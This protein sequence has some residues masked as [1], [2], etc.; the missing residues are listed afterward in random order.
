VQD[1][2]L[3]TSAARE[4]LRDPDKVLAYLRQSVV[5]LARDTLRR[6]LVARRH[7]FAAGALADEMY[8]ALERHDVVRALRTLPRRFREVLVLRY[9]A[10]LDLTEVADLLHISVGAVKS[11]SSRGLALLGARL[12]EP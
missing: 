2:Y 5:N 1:A 3:R 6:R 9:Y 4:R 7:D 11:Y 12:G 10:D 8:A